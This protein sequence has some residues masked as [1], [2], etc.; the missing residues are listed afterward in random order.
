MIDRIERIPLRTIWKHEARD[1]TTWMAENLE[2]LTEVIGQE[3]SNPI[4][5]Q[6]TGNFNVDIKCED[7]AGNNVIIENQLEKS[8]HDHLGKVITYLAAF[9]ARMAIWVVAEPRQEHIM[10]INWLNE[11]GS[12]CDF[13]LLKIEGVRIGNSNPAPLLTK[14]VGPSEEAKQV[15]KI[16][17]EDSE[18]HRLRLQFWT[19]FLDKAKEE[20]KLFKNISAS[21]DT[22]IGASSG[23]RGI[24]Y[25]Y[26]LTQHSMRAELR[27]DLGRDKGEE[28]LAVFHQLKTKK[29]QIEADYGGKLEWNEAEGY[30]VCIIRKNLTKGGY[31]D[32]EKWE[33]IAKEA[34]DVM[35]RLEKA[36]IDHVKKLK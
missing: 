31:K 13:Y 10:A 17:K 4:T 27:I 34:L 19:K 3:L 26:W 7:A 9:E 12:N 1:F 21:K 28:N 33:S 2:V 29:E 32:E 30:R 20:H 8:N 14:I 16:K 11:S 22:W 36:T 35:M 18:R 6:S 15:G 5:E 25:V 24:Q 23:V